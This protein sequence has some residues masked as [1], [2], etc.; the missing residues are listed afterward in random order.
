M[1]R[2]AY[3]TASR[4][5]L[6]IAAALAGHASAQPTAAD[7][8]PAAATSFLGAELPQMEAAVAARDRDYFEAAMGRTLE[9]SDSWGFKTRANP[10]LARY[11][12]CT[13]AVSDFAIVGLCRLMPKGEVCE[14][15]LAPRFDTNLQRCRDL[16]AK[17]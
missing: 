16:A 1:N 14:P 7:Q 12:S 4:V 10:A 17:P 11:A 15:G 5:A 9:F 6:S 3:R 13:E 8:F 2:T